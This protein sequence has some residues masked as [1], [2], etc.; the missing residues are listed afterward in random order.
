MKKAQEIL[1]SLQAQ[2]RFE[3]LH[4]LACIKRILS[5]FL[6]TLQRFVE[7]GYIKNGTLFVVLNHSAGKQEFDNSIKMIKEVLKEVKI[8]E[9]SAVNFSDIRSFVTNK[10]R[11]RSKIEQ[12][13]TVPLYEERALGNFRLDVFKDEQLLEIAYEIREIVRNNAHNT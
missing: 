5:L 13:R 10:P 11:R 3:K 9:C 7:F 4:T 2:P 6:P 12:K 8:E 1:S